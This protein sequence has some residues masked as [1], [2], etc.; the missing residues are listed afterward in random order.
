MMRLLVAAL[1]AALVAALSDAANLPA[2]EQ[3]PAWRDAPA[4]PLK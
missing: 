2:L 1:L 3:F 4:E